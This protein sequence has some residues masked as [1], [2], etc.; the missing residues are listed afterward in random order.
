MGNFGLVSWN[1]G[2]SFLGR[3]GNLGEASQNSDASFQGAVRTGKFGLV[4]WNSEASF[5]GA[6]RMGLFGSVLWILE[7]SNSG[8]GKKKKN[9][10]MGPVLLNLEKIL[11][12]EEIGPFW[13]GF[14]EF[15][16][17]SLGTGEN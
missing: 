7:V 13:A 6:V 5:G 10:H 17:E 4:S 2:A 1:S 9:G 15:G 3:S 11:G 14:V 12:M 8:T 16:G